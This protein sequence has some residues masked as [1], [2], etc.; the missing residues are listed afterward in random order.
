VTL[1]FCFGGDHHHDGIAHGKGVRFL[2]AKVVKWT[3]I[4]VKTRNI[5]FNRHKFF[6]SLL[7]FTTRVD[8][9]TT[10]CSI[11]TIVPVVMRF[12]MD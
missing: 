7:V 8:I 2:L 12:L 11:R 5:R 9:A 4:N 3:T 10:L 6:I 1:L